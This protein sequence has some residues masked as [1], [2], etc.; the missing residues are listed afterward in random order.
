MSL[1]TLLRLETRPLCPLRRMDEVWRDAVCMERV[2]G[3]DMYDKIPDEV[4]PLVEQ[5][6]GFNFLV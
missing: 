4:K 1:L 5:F 3:C 6:L 2:V